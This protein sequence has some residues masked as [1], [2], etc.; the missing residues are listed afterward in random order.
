MPVQNI[1]IK[2]LYPKELDEGIWGGEAVVQGFRKKAE[3]K[4]RVAKFWTPRLI[5][6]VVYSEVLDKHMKTVVTFRT[7]DLIQAHYGFDHYLL[8]VITNNSLVFKIKIRHWLVKLPKFMNY[9]DASL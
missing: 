9:L 1:P 4:E 7:L 6:S 5:K 3:N 2:L 8:K